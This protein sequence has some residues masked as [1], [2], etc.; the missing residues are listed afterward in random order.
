MGED[1]S[2][3]S[4]GSDDDESG[5]S[6]SYQYQYPDPIDD[7]KSK[8]AKFLNSEKSIGR[9]EAF[10]YSLQFQPSNVRRERVVMVA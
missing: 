9:S 10:F 8:L 2:S 6:S 3:R 5:G 1:R 4:D 7:P